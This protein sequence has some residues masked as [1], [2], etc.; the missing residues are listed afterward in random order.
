[1]TIPWNAQQLPTAGT[2]DDDLFGLGRHA[3]ALSGVCF[4]NV[5]R[6]LWKTSR[7]APDSLFIFFPPH[8]RTR[9]AIQITA[10]ALQTGRRGEGGAVIFEGFAAS[11]PFLSSAW[12]RPRRQQKRSGWTFQVLPIVKQDTFR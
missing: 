4:G 2:L 9:L 8:P 3:F 1:M 11:T 7:Q 5:I 6:P 12:P 10:V